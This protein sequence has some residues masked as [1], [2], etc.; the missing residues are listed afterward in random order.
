MERG[1]CVCVCMRT[2]SVTAPSLRSEA[3]LNTFVQIVRRTAGDPVVA[4]IKCVLL[5]L[6]SRKESENEHRFRM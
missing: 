5:L 3:S 2:K 1:V 6:V 4:N